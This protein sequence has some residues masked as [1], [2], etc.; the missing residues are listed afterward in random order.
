M[1]I[2]KNFDGNKTILILLAVDINHITNIKNV[3]KL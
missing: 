2:M 3:K 1:K